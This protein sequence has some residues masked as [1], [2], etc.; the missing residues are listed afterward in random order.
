VL[1]NINDV[2]SAKNGD[3]LLFSEEVKLPSAGKIGISMDSAPNNTG[4]IIAS[5]SKHGAGSKAKLQKGDL[6]KKIGTTV[7][8]N[9]TDVM[10]WALDKEP[11]FA[12][13]F[14]IEK[15]SK[16]IS[17]PLTLGKPRPFRHF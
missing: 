13:T 1:N 17:L 10:L 12:T 8:Q 3:Y 7:I 14:V 11:E 6:I 5:V 4:V 2:P 15:K 9:S 16:L